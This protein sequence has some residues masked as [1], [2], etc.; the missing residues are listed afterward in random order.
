MLYTNDTDLQSDFGDKALIDEPRG[1]V[2]S[3][4]VRDDL[5]PTHRQ[6]LANR[7]LCTH[8]RAAPR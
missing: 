8:R 4:R 3:T 2:Y 5:T 7:N 6:L 1:K